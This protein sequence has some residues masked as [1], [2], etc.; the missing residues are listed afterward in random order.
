MAAFRNFK[1]YVFCALAFLLIAIS[2]QN[3]SG[4]FAPAT[5]SPQTQPGL[6]LSADN[7]PVNGYTASA[8]TLTLLGN[9][10]I[11][12]D[13]IL[14]G[15][16][17][18]DASNG[19]LS[20]KGDLVLSN[21][22][23]LTLTNGNLKFPQTDYSQHAVTLNNQSQLKLINST[24]ITNATQ[25]NNFSMSLDAYNTSVVDFQNSSLSTETGSWLL[26]NFKDSS[27]LI[28]TSSH[29]LPTEIYPSGSSNIAI[30]QGSTFGGLWLEFASG[31]NGTINVP[32][33]NNQG[34]YNL[35][36]GP[37]TGIGYSVNVSAS[38][39]R[40]GIHSYPNSTTII[41]GNGLSGTNDVDIILGYYVVNNT[42]A[43]N[44]TGLTVGPNITRQFVDQGRN[45][46]LNNVNLSPFTWQIYASQN[47]NFPV[48]ITNSKINEVT[49]F[50]NGL[51][52]VSNSVLQLAVT[53]AVGPGSKLNIS[54]TQIWA[55]SILAQ[56][57]GQITIADS[58]LHGNFISAIGA[59]SKITMTNVGESKN[60]ISP[61][62]CSAVDG[63]PPNSSGVPLCNPFNPLYA[64]SQ[65][66][67]PTGGAT[68]TAT[69]SLACPP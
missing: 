37:T 23:K 49:L 25:Q 59:G 35:N 7:C 14:S 13:V 38:K 56:N 58:Q 16:A 44:L 1:P 47:N 57:G 22:A 54:S 27:R 46:Q 53:G 17:I 21:T 32:T 60:G 67:T 31:S 2:F 9:C 45:L 20:I 11:I 66:A 41:N 33:K 63:Y 61:Q 29:D 62:S 55:Q 48:N 64:C 18:V 28:M 42:A 65:I 50:T 24:F 39:G 12:G 5:S 40:L 8:N 30:S 52:N 51:V 68:V 43:V 36:F 69:P 19:T 34:N 6:A 10:E 15:S 3:C 26:G 4:G